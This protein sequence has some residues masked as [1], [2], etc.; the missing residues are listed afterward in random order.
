MKFSKATREDVDLNLTP[1]IDVVFLLL[2][3][4]M[5]STTF[6]KESQI[7]IELPSANTTD[8][9]PQQQM[10]VVTIDSEDRY[11][12][13]GREVVNVQPE[14]LRNTLQK[15]I[16]ETGNEAPQVVINADKSSR[17]QA[18]IT[19]IDVLAQLQITNFVFSTLQRE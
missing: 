2:I 14:Q 13:N 18:V 11:F 15:V 3:F 8:A 9:R 1:L 16:T 19:V 4:F 5:V 7:S 12:I 10:I 17:H 6:E